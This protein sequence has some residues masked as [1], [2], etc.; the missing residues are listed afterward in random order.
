MKLFL[1]VITLI[2]ILTSCQSEK[3]NDAPAQ[4]P[5]EE[6]QV[7]QTVESFYA[8]FNA[9]EFGRVAE[10]TTED[11]NH[12]NP[13]GGLTVGR[14]AV[15]KELKEVHSTFLKGVSS[16]IEEMSVR[17]ATSDA[18]IVTVKN[19]MDTYTTPDGVRRENERQIKT[20]VV[21]KRNGKWLIMHDQNTLIGR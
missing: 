12:I 20:F 4:T 13:F 17:F 16:T 10:Y 8:N 5:N 21:V 14:E 2:I 15:L 3:Q 1:L 11:W 9:H 18:A 6:K 7:R 19:R